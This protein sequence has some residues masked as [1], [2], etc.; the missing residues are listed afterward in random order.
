M[1]RLQLGT[2]GAAL[3]MILSACGSTETTETTTPLTDTS[4]V[5]LS[6]GAAGKACQQGGACDAVALTGME[7]G[8]YLHNQVFV[9]KPKW[10]APIPKEFIHL[11]GVVGD[12]TVKVDTVPGFLSSFHYTECSMEACTPDWPSPSVWTWLN[13]SDVIPNKVGSLRVAIPV[14]TLL[15]AKQYGP[16]ELKWKLED[17][18]TG[19][20]SQWISADGGTVTLDEVVFDQPLGYQLIEGNTLCYKSALVGY[21]KGHLLLYG[22]IPLSST[23][24]PNGP[25]EQT[26][27]ISGDFLSR[28]EVYG[29]SDPE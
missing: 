27:R 7:A 13:L 26:V 29:C 12:Q 3:L 1:K 25:R 23:P 11:W 6:E 28:I 10:C 16:K 18:Q 20:I 8:C 14:D 5:T 4:A 24:P 21:L 22:K 2:V 9:G 19:G 17:S 15:T